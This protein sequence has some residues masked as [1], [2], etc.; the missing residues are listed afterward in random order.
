M[1]FM[2]QVFDRKITW[3]ALLPQF[4]NGIDGV[5]DRALARWPRSARPYQLFD[6][7]T[8]E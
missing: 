2:N 7:V 6:Y 1:A 4:A 5:T 8:V 3:F